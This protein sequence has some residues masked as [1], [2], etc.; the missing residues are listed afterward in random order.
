MGTRNWQWVGFGLTDIGLSKPN[1]S[2]NPFKGV[3]TSN[4]NKQ[5]QTEPIG[6][7]GFS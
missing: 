4:I 6:L 5:N 2:L 1:Q 7:I 3:Q